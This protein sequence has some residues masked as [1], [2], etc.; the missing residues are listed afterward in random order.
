[1]KH[2][3]N[4]CFTKVIREFTNV[5]VSYNSTIVDLNS[6]VTMINDYFAV[7]DLA[8][9]WQ[10]HAA[11]RRLSVHLGGPEC[12]HGSQSQEEIIIYNHLNVLNHNNLDVLA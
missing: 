9:G 12:S 1:M 5:S 3:F 11:C 6:T 2:I 4:R 8:Y 7:V 10:A